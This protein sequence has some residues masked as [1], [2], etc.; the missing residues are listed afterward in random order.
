MSESIVV[1]R[2]SRNLRYKLTYIRIFETYLESERQTVVTE[3]LR[4]LLQAYQMAIGPL[5]SYLR[6]MDV[7]AQ[8]L[9]LD[10]KLLDHAFSRS[11][12]E[13][14][15][16]FIHDGLSRAASWYKTQ[17]A[18]RQMTADPDLRQLLVELGEIDAAKLW[19][20][21]AVMAA[22]RIPLTLK[23]SDYE[24]VV[25]EPKTTEWR[26]RLVDDVRRPNWSGERSPSPRSGPDTQ[27]RRRFRPGDSRPRGRGP[28]RSEPDR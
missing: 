15:L 17:L 12:T 5:A 22:L 6:R 21:E 3:L 1:I 2:L 8:E 24:P 16:R 20:T 19:R 13:S 23:E 18:D 25:S 14:Q 28:R 7:A 27:E 11:N 10:E 26:P 4:S 9:E